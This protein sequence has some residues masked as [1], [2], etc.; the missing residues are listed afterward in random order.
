MFL[1]VRETETVK[2]K[3]LHGGLSMTKNNNVA[4]QKQVF[5]PSQE[6]SKRTLGVRIWQLGGYKLCKL[7]TDISEVTKHHKHAA[8]LEKIS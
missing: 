6:G 3:F 7:K 8:V 5:R 1:G 2:I 4:T